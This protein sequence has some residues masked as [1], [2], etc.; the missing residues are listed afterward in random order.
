MWTRGPLFPSC[1]N[2]ITGAGGGYLSLFRTLFSGQCSLS[3]AIRQAHFS[4]SGGVWWGRGEGGHPCTI[5]TSVN[6]WRQHPLFGRFVSVNCGRTN[7]A[8]LRLWFSF[9]EKPKAEN[10]SM[11][12]Q[13]EVE[14]T[15]TVVHVT[16]RSIFLWLSAYTPLLFREK[17]CLTLF[18]LFIWEVINLTIT[19]AIIITL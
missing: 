5:T 12:R 10:I 2:W 15:F 3:E 14:S 8:A 4:G 7:T 19:L 17:Y 6:L 16:Y 1:I 18:M 9:G 13:L 11:C